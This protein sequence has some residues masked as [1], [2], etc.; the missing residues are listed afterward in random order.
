MKYLIQV[1]SGK[2]CKAYAEQR[3]AAGYTPPPVY[4]WMNNRD[5]ILEFGKV[6]DADK[7]LAQVVSWSKGSNPRRKYSRN[8][9]DVDVL[10][11]LNGVAK[12]YEDWAAWVGD[13]VIV[14]ESYKTRNSALRLEVTVP[15]RVLY[16]FQTGRW[17]YHA[18]YRHIGT[19]YMAD[20]APEEVSLEIAR[21][22]KFFSLCALS[23]IG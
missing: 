17:E 13:W 10:E 11:A 9:V 21:G 5:L 8:V 14:L 4:A 12:S 7:C 22:G 15:P 20:P 6:A 18:G 16:R 23:H 3:Y 19:N 1:V 2:D